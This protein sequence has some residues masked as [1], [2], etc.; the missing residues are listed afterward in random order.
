MEEVQEKISM[1]WK[2]SVSVVA[3]RYSDD[4][5]ARRILSQLL[6]VSNVSEEMLRLIMSA[7]EDSV[8]LLAP[9]DVAPSTRE[10]RVEQVEQ[11]EEEEEERRTGTPQPFPTSSTSPP[12]EVRRIATIDKVET[13]AAAA[14][15]SPGG[16][17]V[18]AG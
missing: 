12:R 16:E 11:E 10:E 5:E 4:P 8:Q 9:P 3:T 17:F 6:D 13:A 15:W 14:E 1:L 7:P 2:T 18:V